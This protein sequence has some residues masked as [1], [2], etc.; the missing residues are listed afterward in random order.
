MCYSS[1]CVPPSLPDLPSLTREDAVWRAQCYAGC[2]SIVRKKLAS[3]HDFSFLGQYYMHVTSRSP[4][5]F[6][7]GDVAHH[8]PVYLYKKLA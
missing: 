7:K 3:T 8:R 2:A 1:E 4:K 6:R 5:P